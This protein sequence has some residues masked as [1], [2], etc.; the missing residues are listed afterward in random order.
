LKLP[1]AGT[2]KYS[3]PSELLQVQGEGVN[4][5]SSSPSGDTVR[6]VF[7]GVYGDVRAYANA[8]RANGF[9]VRCFRNVV[10][11]QS[12]AGEI[13]YSTTEATNQ[14]VLVTLT[15]NQTGHVVEAGRT[16]TGD[17]D[18]VIATPYEATGVAISRQK[19]FPANTTETVHFTESVNST[20]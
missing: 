5:W 12:I 14:D 20:Q 1:L 7:L 3:S 11:V 16:A 17:N 4:Y 9:P 8:A 6:N 13:S 10:S 19:T 2:R 18:A 15:L